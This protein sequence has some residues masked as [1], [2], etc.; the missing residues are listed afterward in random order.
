MEGASK[1]RTASQHDLRTGASSER[2]LLYFLT[3]MAHHPPRLPDEVA[4]LFWDV[5]P[6]AV[7]LERH[8]DYVLERV[9]SRGGW[10]AMKWLRGVYSANSIG[11]FVRRKGTR[12]APRDL[13]YW[14]LIAGTDVAIPTGGGR[15]PWARR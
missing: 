6:E 2:G 12:L 1:R 4:R 9:M 13:A 5:D 3:A 10:S 15:P 8:R 11:E 7:D 14:A